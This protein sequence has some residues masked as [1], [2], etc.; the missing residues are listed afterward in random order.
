MTVISC[1]AFNLYIRRG[2]SVPGV[3]REEHLPG[4]FSWHYSNLTFSP[5]TI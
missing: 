3:F 5:Y 2:L 1:G 4:N